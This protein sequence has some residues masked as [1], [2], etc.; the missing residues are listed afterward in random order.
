MADVMPAAPGSPLRHGYLAK[1]PALNLALRGRDAWLKLRSKDRVPGTGPVPRRMLIC[2]GGHL[3]DAIL[4]SGVFPAL[5]TAY[6]DVAIGVLAPSWSLPVFE[7]HPALHWRH[8]LDHWKT[9]RSGSPIE[10][11]LAYR[12]SIVRA[13][14]ELRETGYDTAV[15]LYPFFPNAADVLAA[16]SIPVRIG[17]TSGG[18]GPLYTHA[19]PWVETSRHTVDQ[20]LTLMRAFL[21]AFPAELPAYDLPPIGPIAEVRGRALLERVGLDHHAYV[22]LHPGAGD[23]RKQ[24]PVQHWRALADRLRRDEPD[25]RIVLTGHGASDRALVDAIRSGDDSL[26]SVCDRTTWNEL[27]FLLG[28]AA[29][30]IGVDSMAVHLAAAADVPCIAIMA[31]MSDPSHWRP[32]GPRAHAL[33]N[34]VPCAPCF[35]SKGCAAMQCVR[36]VTVDSVERTAVALLRSA[37]TSTA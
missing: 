31:A 2:I 7:N 21:P 8:S 11:W 28:S 23:R 24:W 16:A 18:G 5:R 15:D 13:L 35:R 12:H 36:G 6:P 20:H 30:V 14:R 4:A 37:R 32:L 1:H 19:L 25:L 26:M 17:Y 27:R 34:L 9:N 29:L 10:R 22:V 33:V 3:G